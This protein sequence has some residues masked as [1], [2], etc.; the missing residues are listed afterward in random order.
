MDTKEENRL[1]TKEENRLKT[2]VKNLIKKNAKAPIQRS[3]EWYIARYIA[4]NASEANAC[5]TH[6][7]EICRDYMTQFNL[8]NFQL[9]N[10]CCSHFDTKEDFIIN[11]GRAFFGENVF[12]DSIYTLWGKKYEEIATRMYRLVYNIPVLE[13]GSLPHPRLSWLRC[14]PDGITPNGTLLEIKCPFKRKITGICPFHYYTQCMIQLEVCDLEICDY[15]ECEIIEFQTEQEYIDY[16]LTEN[17]FKGILMNKTNEENN[18]E[19]KYIYPP[20]YLITTEDFL[21]WSNTLQSIKVVPIYYC[22]TKWNVIQ[23]KRNKVWFDTIIKPILKEAHQ[24]FRKLQNDKDLFDKYRESIHLIKN[25]KFIETYN[26]T[27]CLIDDESNIETISDECLLS[28][29]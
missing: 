29:N 3:P 13:F 28:E 2:K 11:K 8:P 5:L 25:K 27:V 22:I 17:Q 12:K 14:S 19:T 16:V 15:L 4:I 23:I 24:F 21:N 6:T 9:D 26:K 18:S 1:K 7:E 10:K 20:D